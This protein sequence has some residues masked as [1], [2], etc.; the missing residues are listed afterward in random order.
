[1]YR[2]WKTQV[3]KSGN[4]LEHPRFYLLQD[5]SLSIK[6]FIYLSIHIHIHAYPYLCLHLNSCIYM[7]ISIP[8]SISISIYIYVQL[9]TYIL[10][11]CP[12]HPSP[13]IARKVNRLKQLSFVEPRA[14]QCQR[15][16]SKNL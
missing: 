2:I 6:L 3:R 7:S 4:I 1:M 10:P 11:S 8:I 15:V 12:L 14:C 9:C 13:G 5:D 16:D